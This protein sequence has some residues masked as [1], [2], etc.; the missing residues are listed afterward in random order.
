MNPFYDQN[1]T[2]FGN[3]LYELLE[4]E[5]TEERE[6]Y[7]RERENLRVLAKI[8]YVNFAY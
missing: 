1:V 6:Y 2:K 5:L 8:R 7:E 4:Q 3:K